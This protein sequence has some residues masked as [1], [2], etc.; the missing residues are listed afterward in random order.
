MRKQLPFSL[1]KISIG[2]VDIP[3]LLHYFDYRDFL[4]DFVAH[5]KSLQPSWSLGAWAKHL[6]LSGTASISRILSG[7]RIPGEELT[8]SLAGYFEFDK[9]NER[10]FRSM[11][12]KERYYRSTTLPGEPIIV[13]RNGKLVSLIGYLD[14]EKASQYLQPFGLEPLL[15]AGIVATA[16]TVN[17]YPDTT[18]G[19]FGESYFCFAVRPI[20]GGLL[21]SGLFFGG[22][23][24]N[25]ASIASVYASFDGHRPE[26][27]AVE[28]ANTS[29]RIQA[30]VGASGRPLFDLPDDRRTMERFEEKYEMNMYATRPSG[31][32][33]ARFTIDSSGI[34]RPFDSATDRFDLEVNRAIFAELGNLDF[35]PLKWALHEN[36]F[37]IIHQPMPLGKPGTY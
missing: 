16:I 15:T 34:T 29:D 17:R 31:L 8:A 18:A 25:E 19:A 32:F 2:S 22:F 23:T 3:D 21:D 28:I 20:G 7:E 14:F 5:K 26:I 13:L 37:S 10:L 12:E 24:C 1:Q 11:V 30:R 35:K 9:S 36:L 4:R 6:E 27:G 33:R